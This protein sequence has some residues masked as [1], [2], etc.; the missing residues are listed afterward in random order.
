MKFI[1]LQKFDEFETLSDI[2]KFLK[3]YEELILASLNFIIKRN[4]DVTIYNFFIN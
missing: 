3:E 2:I 1:N 4:E